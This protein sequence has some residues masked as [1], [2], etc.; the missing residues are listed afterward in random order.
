MV[1]VITRGMVG[2]VAFITSVWPFVQVV[3]KISDDASG[4]NV[5]GSASYL[6]CKGSFAF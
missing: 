1:K 3:Y 6:H 4:H 2:D 5:A